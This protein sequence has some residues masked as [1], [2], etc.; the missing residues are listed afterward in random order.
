M[1]PQLGETVLDPACG[2]GGFLAETYE[3]PQIDPGNSL[4]FYLREIGE[5]DRVDVI[6]TNPPFGGEEERGILGNFPDDMQTSET[7]LLF[8]QL[9]NAWK[10]SADDVWKNNYNLDIK[11]PN[12]AKA[13][14]FRAPEE[15][16]ASVVEKEKRIFELLE[17]IQE[18]ISKGWNDAV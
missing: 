7:A 5:K 6:M 11:N 12:R 8:L 15:I 1:D 16:V 9:I 13:E 10:V 18:Q 2:T 17:E 14:E 3:H 4:R